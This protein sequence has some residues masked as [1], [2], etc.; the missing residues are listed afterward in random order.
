MQQY[1]KCICACKDL[2]ATLMHCNE[3]S[4]KHMAAH[5]PI[6]I[7]IIGGIDVVHIGYSALTRTS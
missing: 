3:A 7:T 2:Y 4:I 6:G 5:T 1:C